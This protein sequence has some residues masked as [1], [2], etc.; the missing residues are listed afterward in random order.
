M[1]P[2]EMHRQIRAAGFIPAQRNTNYD[3]LKTFGAVDE[4]DELK[5]IQEIE[6]AASQQGNWAGL[7][8]IE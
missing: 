1:L 8:L 6:A 3:V 7:T 2:S 4:A 5:S